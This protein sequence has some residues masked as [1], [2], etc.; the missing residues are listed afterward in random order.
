MAADDRRFASEALLGL[1]ILLAPLAFGTTESW[2]RALLAGV[3]S[4]AYLTHFFRMGFHG[5]LPHQTPPL[6]YALLL[7]IGLACIQALNPVSPTALGTRPF[8]FTLSRAR[9]LEWIFDNAIYLTSLLF[10]PGIFRAKGSLERLSWLLLLCG[11]V[12]ALVGIAQQQAGNEFYYGFRKVS[13]FRAPFGPFPNKNHAGG[14]LAMCALAGLGL[15]VQMFERSETRPTG[16]RKDEFIGRLTILLSLEFIVLL[17]LFRANS[18]GAVIACV[19][20]GSSFAI[21]H[22]ISSRRYSRTTTILF[23]LFSLAMVAATSHFAGVR[24]SSYIPG[25]GENSVTFRQAMI[26]DG[27]KIVVFAPWTGIGLG[28]LKAAYPLWMDPVM[29]G[30]FTEHLHCDPLELAAEAGIPLAA[31]YYSAFLATIALSIRPPRITGPSALRLA[32]AAAGG[33]FLI[34]QAIDFPA[35]I[36]SLQFIAITCISAA[37]ANSLPPDFESPQKPRISPSKRILTAIIFT[38]L[39]AYLLFPRFAA[40]YFDL[41]A[42]QYLQPS[43][44]YFQVQALRW[45]P[46]FERNLELARSYWQISEENP[47]ARTISLRTSLRYTD[48]ALSLEPLHPE[49]RRVRSILL[50]HLG[51]KLNRLG[52]TIP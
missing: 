51:P 41:L 9:T 21:L 29:K 36:M 45:E 30:F 35:H 31:I 26:V 39:S 34:H 11:A 33:A 27:L 28:A 7:L 4:L 49:A 23:T 32:L 25:V 6:F 38:G 3:L 12:I 52:K 47:A 48:A 10:L 40:A 44:Q 17:G 37:W 13:L 24:W 43:K 22:L 2:S 15:V 42:S 50:F 18:R 14:F 16:E 1:G 19:A 5:R 46:T 20:A 8:F